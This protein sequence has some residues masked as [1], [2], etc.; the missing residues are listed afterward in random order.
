MSK[1]VDEVKAMASK[2]SSG[3]VVTSNILIGSFDKSWVGAYSLKEKRVLWWYKSET[4]VASPISSFGG[5]IVFGLRDG[6]VIKLEAL[7]GKKIWEVDL[8]H[9][10]SHP[11]SRSG[12]SLFALS[13]NN[14]LFCLDFQSGKTNWIYDGGAP[15]SLIISNHTKPQIKDKVVYIGTSDGE[16]HAV[17]ISKG[18]LLWKQNVAFTEGRF[19]D[20]VGDLVVLDN[21]II[22]TR[23][24]G[25]VASIRTNRD[26]SV[27][28]KSN[29]STVTTS[30]YR[31]GVLFVGG[32]NG[33]IHAL[34][35]ASGRHIWKTN[36]GQSVANVTVGEK[37]LYAAG[38]N[39]RIT[40]INKVNGVPLWVDDIEGSIAIKPIILDKDIFFPTGLKALYG[41]RFL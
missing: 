21:R 24:D 38:T 6:R 29:F 34:D 2:D 18:V 13:V 1:H 23:Y 11:F 10:I 16:V 26:R 33:D 37:F 19:H 30:G 17:D 5:W 41:Y 8:G 15:T 36:T 9:F 3:W 7:T 40:A 39:G 28:W 14:Q 27:Y 31:E 35:A 22:V 12:S 4:D 25:V 20:V 32:I